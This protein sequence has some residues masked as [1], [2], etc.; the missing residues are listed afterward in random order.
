MK[1][2][3]QSNLSALNST[4]SLSALNHSTA[5]LAAA[6]AAKGWRDLSSEIYAAESAD[7]AKEQ[8]L[9]DVLQ[10]YALQPDA[11]HGWELLN[12]LREAEAELQTQYAYAKKQQAFYQ[13]QAE[14]EAKSGGGVIVDWTQW[15]W[16][17]VQDFF[18]SS[19]EA[20]AEK[21]ARLAV[22]SQRQ[23]AELS[24]WT[25]ALQQELLVDSTPSPEEDQSLP[26]STEAEGESEA[27]EIIAIDTSTS[28]ATQRRL[29]QQA[30]NQITVENPIPLQYAQVGQP[31]MLIAD[32]VFNYTDGDSISFGFECINYITP[33]YYVNYSNQKSIDFYTPT[34]LSFDNKA[35]F[36]AGTPQPHDEGTLF[37]NLSAIN[38]ITDNSNWI[39]FVLIVRILIL[40]III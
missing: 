39:T 21:Y 27:E 20:L 31:F 10:S 13:A 36:F 29:L 3:E 1:A 14:Q 7:Q 24:T 38:Q 35:I 6:L 4:G 19:S 34:W 2:F 9:K 37:L 15:L 17:G 8:R 33:A 32:D 16:H 11:H 22:E 28:K 23:Q 25:A 26:E 5:G 40:I 18:G 30:E 12:L